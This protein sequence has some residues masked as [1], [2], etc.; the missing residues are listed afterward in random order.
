MVPRTCGRGLLARY[1]L[2]GPPKRRGQEVLLDRL[3]LFQ[4]RRTKT[5]KRLAQARVPLHETQVA[6]FVWA[7][8][9]AENR[10]EGIFLRTGPER[11]RSGIRSR[12]M[13]MAM[14]IGYLT[15]ETV[16]HWPEIEA[17][18]GQAGGA[19]QAAADREE[20]V[21]RDFGS[22]GYLLRTHG[23]SKWR[24]ILWFLVSLIVVCV[25]SCLRARAHGF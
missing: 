10:E 8:F 1:R 9:G 6:P 23:I 15:R 7:G 19:E 2:P 14:A 16:A 11:E 4:T 3:Q 25:L 17:E 21:P 18:V 12:T 22:A 5:H 24:A 20:D 13:A